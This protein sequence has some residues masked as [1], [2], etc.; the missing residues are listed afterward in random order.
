LLFALILAYR[1]RK[2]H[3]LGGVLLILLC[4]L[5]LAGCG[6]SSSSSNAAKGTYSLT[7]TGTDTATASITASTTM[8]L[9]ID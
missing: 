5:V 8:M 1:P 4:G 2:H 3:S 7:I 6:S 9:T